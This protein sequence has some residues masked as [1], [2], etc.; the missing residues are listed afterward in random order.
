[1]TMRIQSAV[2]YPRRSRR[3]CSRAFS[4]G[5]ERASE[6]SV[7]ANIATSTDRGRARTGHVHMDV[8]DLHDR[9]IRGLVDRPARAEREVGQHHH[10]VA[11]LGRSGDAPGLLPVEVEG[12]GVG[13]DIDAI[14]VKAAG[15]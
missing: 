10:L 5:L 2:S 7:S 15:Q 14:S 9:G 1:M 12:D 8:I 3:P 11:Q 6:V 13:L 4:E